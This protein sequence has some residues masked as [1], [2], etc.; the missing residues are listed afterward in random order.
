[1][2]EGPEISRVCELF[3]SKKGVG[4]CSMLDGQ[5]SAVFELNGSITYERLEVFRSFALFR[6]SLGVA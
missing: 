2:L 5:K 1:M 6:D 3:A 4:G